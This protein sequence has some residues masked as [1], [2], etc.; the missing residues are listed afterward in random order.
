MTAAVRRRWVLL[1][2]TGVPVLALHGAILFV[3][4]PA[5]F[6]IE[7]APGVLVQA[8]QVRSVVRE[9][10]PAMHSLAPPKADERN[11]LR[12]RSRAL[13]RGKNLR[14][15]R[16]RRHQRRPPSHPPARRAR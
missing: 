14:R 6:E 16:P 15:R 7:G 3:L 12:G 2:A 5:W 8:L 9:S 11:A 4:G 13:R 10:R 1:C